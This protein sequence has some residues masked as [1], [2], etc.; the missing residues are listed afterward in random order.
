SLNTKVWS[1]LELPEP[2]DARWKEVRVLD[3]LRHRAG[4]PSNG[5]ND[6]MFRNAEIAK[7]LEVPL[8][9]TT[10]HVVK[11]MEGQKL[12]PDPIGYAYSKV[13]YWI[14]GRI[15]ERVTGMS[16]DEYVR[17]KVCAPLGIHRL[18]LGKTHLVERAAGEVLYYGGREGPAVV[19]PIGTNVPA[20]YGRWS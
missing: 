18:Q 8:P 19:G 1:L 16:Y 10:A 20:P 5:A 7:A 2:T 6:P 3:L 13:G 14:L 17:T 4:C 15:I 11:F 9:I 12:N